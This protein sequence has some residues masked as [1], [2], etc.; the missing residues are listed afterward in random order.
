MGIEYTHKICGFHSS[1]YH[2]L[3]R[4]TCSWTE[5][6]A[7]Q[8]NCTVLHFRRETSCVIS[9]FLEILK[10]CSLISPLLLQQ[11]TCLWYEF[12]SRTVVC[13]PHFHCL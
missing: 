1:K 8:P 4:N 11:I 13:L 7:I 2:L 5:A 6:P 12:C 3:G 10:T 9:F